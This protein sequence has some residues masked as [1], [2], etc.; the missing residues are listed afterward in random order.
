MSLR[1]IFV[2]LSLLAVGLHAGWG[3]IWSYLEGKLQINPCILFVPVG[4]GL[5][6]GLPSARMVADGLFKAFYVFGFLACLV[7]IAVPGSSSAKAI[8]GLD[9]IWVWAVFSLA[10]L[11]CLGFLHWLLFTQPFDEWLTR[12]AREHAGRPDRETR[13]RTRG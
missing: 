10:F 7:A 6:L 12:G 5:A 2:V 11:A 1:V 9:G 13:G 3:M 8:W 4:I